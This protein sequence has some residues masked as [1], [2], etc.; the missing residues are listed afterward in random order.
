MYD[1]LTGI[2]GLYNP[3]LLGVVK[4]AE[5]L[6]ASMM[7]FTSGSMWLNPLPDSGKGLEAVLSESTFAAADVDC[8]EFPHISKIKDPPIGFADIERSQY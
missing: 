1:C 4:D 5:E 8:S 6:A 3:L 7:D 2:D